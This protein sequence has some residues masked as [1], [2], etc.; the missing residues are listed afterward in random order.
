MEIDNESTVEQKQKHTRLNDQ[1]EYFTNLVKRFAS[2]VA[3]SW[4]L[5]L[6]WA[7]LIML[8][9]NKFLF[10]PSLWENDNIDG[11]MFPPARALPSHGEPDCERVLA[12]CRFQR[13]VLEER[14][15]LIFPTPLKISENKWS[16]A[17]YKLGLIWATMNL[18][19]KLKY[20][21][22]QILSDCFIA[23]VTISVLNCKVYVARRARDSI[24]Q[25]QTRFDQLWDRLF[26]R[27]ECCSTLPKD[28]QRI[29]ED[30]SRNIRDCTKAFN[31]QIAGTHETYGLTPISSKEPKKKHQ[32]FRISNL[33]SST[34]RPSSST[35]SSS[36]RSS[37]SP[38]SPA[39]P[40]LPSARTGPLPTSRG[41][42]RPA[43]RRRSGRSSRRASRGRRGR[44]R[45][46]FRG[47]TGGDVS[48]LVDAV[49][50]AIVFER[51]EDVC[52]AVEAITGDREL[53]VI[54]MKSRFDEE[55][56][57]RVSAGYR[58]VSMNVCVVREESVMV[59]VARH[60]F[61]LQLVLRLFMLLRNA[62]GHERYVSFQNLRE[63]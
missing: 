26:E 50:E 32:A 61:E 3:I 11:W 7:A 28:S 27:S 22:Y 24:V 34:R 15:L 31:L 45:R 62:S 43:G 47:R 53:R 12:A 8:S 56:D 54:W 17:L 33:T 21:N 46:S 37:K 29:D 39:A 36:A 51:L 10:D 60:V 41:G 20:R 55:Y 52:A 44:W 49:R 19:V 30:V 6:V 40:S 1:A 25:D 57:S 4:S 14:T 42:R 35:P 18:I 58:D 63:E 9:P 59:G 48:R 23:A 13:M 16:R 5:L 2:N 38:S